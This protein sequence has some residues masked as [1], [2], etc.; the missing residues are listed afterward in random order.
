MLENLAHTEAM[1]VVAVVVAVV[2]GRE[3]RAIDVIPSELL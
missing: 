1:V 2:A 3:Q